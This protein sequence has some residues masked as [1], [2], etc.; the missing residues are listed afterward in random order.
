MDSEVGC[1]FGRVEKLALERR[2][3][4]E[5]GEN[6][7]KEKGKSEKRDQIVYVG[8]SGLH[9]FREAFPRP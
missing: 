1:A 7:K 3:T 2:H 6:K 8:F 4:M 9:G 5:E